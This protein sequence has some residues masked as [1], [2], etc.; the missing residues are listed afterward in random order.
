ML[1][2]DL[3]KFIEQDHA[4]LS[5]FVRGDPE[6]LK[7]LYSRR[8]DVV[9]ANPF[10]PPARGWEKVAETMEHAAT[11]YR[12]GVVVGFERI[13]EF[14]TE[15][16]RLY[17]RDRAVPSQGR[18]V[19][20]PDPARVTCDNDIP[21]G[22]ER[23]AGRPAT[24]RP[25]YLFAPG[26]VDR[27]AVISPVGDDPIKGVGPLHGPSPRPRPTWPPR[28]SGRWRTPGRTPLRCIPV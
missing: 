2:G 23:L 12:D 14:A 3:T 28:L 1:V 26:G 4:A 7:S 8:D 9:I 27:R 15:N 16:S 18:G 11:N 21:S 24:R 13:S 17:H 6:P 20:E 22:G 10:G 19:G 5:A 25:D